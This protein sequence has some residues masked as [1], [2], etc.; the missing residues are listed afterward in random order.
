M[1][2]PSP[3][4]VRLSVVST[5][6]GSAGTIREFVSRASRAA[7][8]SAGG[9]YEVVLVNDGS[10]D[11]SYSIAIELAQQD[12]H[13]R[14]V[15][16]SRNFGHHVALLEGLSHSVGELV[17]L[18]DSDLEEEPEWLSRFAEAL[19]ARDVDAVFGFQEVR[20]GGAFE[21]VSGAL[22]WR[23]FRSLT[24]IDIPANI[25]TCRLMTRRYVD[26]VLSYPEREVS[27]GGI[28]ASAGFDQAALPVQKGDKGRSTYSTRLK[29]WHLVNS[30]SSF[31]RGPLDVIFVLGI[32]VFVIGLGLVGYLVV[33][34]IAWQ[35]SPAG[36]T[37]VIAS[38]WLLG[39]LTLISLGVIATYLGKV[40]MEVKARPRAVVR[41]VYPEEAGV[42]PDQRPENRRRQ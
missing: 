28:F 20:K 30:I 10:P 38:V 42:G 31:T 15:D 6:Y 39:G 14:V 33:A 29:F 4:T 12:A 3:R 40:F 8:Q 11:D 23:L 35:K 7:E 9:D 21:R 1:N 37:S 36:W 27:I 2:N 17:F 26:A 18:I 19:R 5:L 25:V 22:Y 16:L 34:A 32:S 41:S 24:S 13:L